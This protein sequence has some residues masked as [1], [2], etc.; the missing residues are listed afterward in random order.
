MT[1]QNIQLLIGDFSKTLPVALDKIGRLDYAYI[2]GNHQKTPTLAYFEQCLEYSHS[3][4]IFV[5]D[6]IHWSAEMESAWNEIKE[7]PKVTLTIDLFYMGLIFLSSDKG[8]MQHFSIIPA[9]Y[10]P[11]KIRFGKL[12]SLS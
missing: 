8:E 1:K 6:D 10:K 12:S 11:W 9:K 3:D 4:T 5:F 7:H 2:D